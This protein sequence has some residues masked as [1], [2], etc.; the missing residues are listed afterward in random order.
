[1]EEYFFFKKKKNLYGKGILAITENSSSSTFNK[2]S[3]T[4]PINALMSL[5][6][7][8]EGFSVSVTALILLLQDFASFRLIS[9]AE[10]S[11]MLF[12]HTA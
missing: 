5:I 7:L 3:A 12:Y 11:C 9:A 2:W 6:V 4:C 10:N 8:C 1:V